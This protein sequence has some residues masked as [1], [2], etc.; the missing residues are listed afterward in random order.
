MKILTCAI[1][2]LIV[3]GLI[4]LPSTYAQQPPLVQNEQKQQHPNIVLFLVDNK[5]Y[6]ALGT[7]GGGLGALTPNTDKF[8]QEGIKFTRAYAQPTLI[9]HLQGHH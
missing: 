6:K 2:S 9:V 7:Y 8:A 4:G 5:P 3:L 1:F